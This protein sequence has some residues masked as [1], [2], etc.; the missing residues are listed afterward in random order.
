M[1]GAEELVQQISRGPRLVNLALEQEQDPAE[2]GQV[3]VSLGIVVI[4]K[5]LEKLSIIFWIGIGHLALLL[6]RIQ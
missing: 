2:Q 1:K 6:L 3:L 4:K 5:L